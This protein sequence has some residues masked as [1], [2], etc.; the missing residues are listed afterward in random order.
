MKINVDWLD[1]ILAF[2]L[3]IAALVGIISPTWMKF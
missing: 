2:V 1:T 3:L